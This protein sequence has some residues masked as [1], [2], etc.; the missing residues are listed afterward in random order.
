MTN[1]SK[2]TI[3]FTGDPSTLTGTLPACPALVTDYAPTPTSG[4]KR[5]PSSFRL[6]RAAAGS[7]KARLKAALEMVASLEVRADAPGVEVHTGALYL[8][9]IRRM[10]EGRGTQVSDT[11]SVRVLLRHPCLPALASLFPVLTG[12]RP[13]MPAMV[14]LFYTSLARKCGSFDRADVVA[15]DLWDSVILPELTAMGVTVPKGKQPISYS[16]FR[17]WRDNHVTKERLDALF[18]VHRAF[19]IR[20]AEAIDDSE[21]AWLDSHTGAD[22]RL[23]YDKSLPETLRGTVP[24]AGTPLDARRTQ[25]VATDGT[26][27]RPP[28]EVHIDCPECGHVDQH[29]DDCPHTGDD[30]LIIGSRA[31]TAK[32]ARIHQP[33][34]RAPDKRHGPTAGYQVLVASISGNRAYSTVILDVE[35]AAGDIGEI[36][37]AEALITGVIDGFSPGRIAALLYDGAAGPKFHMSMARRYGIPVVNYPSVKVKPVKGKKSVTA[38]TK[39][40]LT[41]TRSVAGKVTR[42][43]GHHKGEEVEVY[44]FHM[45]PVFHDTAAGSCQHRLISVDGQ[46]QHTDTVGTPG[47]SAKGAS[48][49]DEVN[50]VAY[51]SVAGGDAKDECEV[52]VTV[53]IPCRHGDFDHDYEITDL[54]HADAGSGWNSLAAKVRAVIMRSDAFARMYGSRN[55]AESIFSRLEGMFPIKDRMGSYGM[56][57]QRLDFLGS[58]IAINAL[59]WAHLLAYEA[60]S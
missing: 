1:S 21:V 60:M 7:D 23:N 36:R 35:M 9:G 33:G 30:S 15:G 18:T 48:M 54:N 40:L 43:G 34:R 17:R 31:K 37:F 47:R 16:A 29:E 24:P 10:K 19:S 45:H 6:V 46:L 38:A 59:T 3:T 25:M 39:C 50:V 8:P 41:A 44:T 28:S 11:T 13:Q 22:G 27:M 5:R 12:G 32:A 20:L 57:A 55:I 53:R 42:A 49:G 51:T 58:A 56:D 26:V 52:K 2:T 4:S 14:F